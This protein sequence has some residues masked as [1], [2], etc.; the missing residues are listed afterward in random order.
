MNLLKTIAES[1]AIIMTA[2]SRVVN[3]CTVVMASREH[4]YNGVAQHEEGATH[5]SMFMRILYERDSLMPW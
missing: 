5:L 1:F 3:I 4:T 2:A